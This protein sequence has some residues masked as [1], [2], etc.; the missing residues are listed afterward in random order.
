MIELLVPLGPVFILLIL[1]KT[2]EL[3]LSSPLDHHI[4]RI[5]ILALTSL[6]HLSGLRGSNGL[7]STVLGQ[8][9]PRT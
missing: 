4:Q 5:S 6:L 3:I 1:Q 8:L 2:E 9:G 7:Y